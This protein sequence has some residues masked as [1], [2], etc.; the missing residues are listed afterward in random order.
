MPDI[1]P[2]LGIKKPLAN[3]NA[4]RQAFN[5][6]WDIIDAAAETP[7]GAQTKADNT[8]KDATKEIIIEVRNND[9]SSPAIGRMWFRSDL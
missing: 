3:E 9:P 8:R 5:E 2:R 1:T 6:N 4:T 7:T